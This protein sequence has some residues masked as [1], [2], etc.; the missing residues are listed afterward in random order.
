[1]MDAGSFY[2]VFLSPHSSTAALGYI[3]VPL[4]NLVVFVPL[5]GL[6]GWWVGKRLRQRALSDK[7]NEPTR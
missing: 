5:G 3:F 4:W 7:T 1:M 6:I 2:S